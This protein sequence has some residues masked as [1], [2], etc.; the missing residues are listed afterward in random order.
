MSQPIPRRHPSSPRPV[1]A[2]V[3]AIGGLLGVRG[4]DAERFTRLGRLLMVGDPLMDDF[5]AWM[6]TQESS[7]IRPLFER[8]LAHGIDAVDAPPAPLRTLF[9]TL[10]TV[11]DWVD[12]EQLAKA[13]ATMR[14]AGADGLTIA[15]DVALLGGYQFAGFNQTLLRTGA[16]EKGSNARFAETSQWAMDV[17]APGGLDR[18]GPGYRSTIRVRF[19]HSLVRRH[20]AALPDWDEREWGLP[21]NQTDM[22]ATL[23][24]ALVAPNLGGLGMGIVNRPS[25][26]QAIAAL[27]RYVG[28]LIGVQED[29]LPTD[30]RSAVALLMHTSAALATPDETSR[31]LARPMADDPL[32]WQYGTLTPLRR[33]LARSQHLSVSTAFLGPK[34]MATLG[35]P[36]R[37]PPWYPVLALPGNLLRSGIALL[38]GGR[39]W[40]A[41]RGDRSARALMRTM[42]A[43]PATLGAT[44]TV[45]EHVA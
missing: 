20:V 16:L 41:E 25:E 38:P 26:Y 13:A 17:I 45:A 44:T 39:E 37:T 35:L 22:A 23:V 36:T 28:W 30:F 19:I 4:P 10:E 3:A 15:R 33:H 14:A 8:A 40:T 18:H 12:A 29:L 31:R 2:G 32:Q 42:T 11:P 34:A 27:T 7:S 6:S 21:I 24:G 43:T 5:V 9:E 1:P